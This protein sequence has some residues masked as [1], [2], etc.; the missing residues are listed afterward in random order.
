CLAKDPDRRWQS[1]HDVRLLIESAPESEAPRSD[2]PVSRA[3]RVAPWVLAGAASVAAVAALLARRPSEPASSSTVRFSLPPPSGRTF[4][5]YLE[6]V[7]VAV[8]P[9]GT[10]IVLVVR[11]PDGDS[12]LWL[13]PLSSAQAHPIEG[14]QGGSGPFW[15]PDGRSLGFFVAGQL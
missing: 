2:P 9:D 15:S 3:R 8:S 4:G 11:E 12:R 1:A 14:T 6:A 7:P 5:S 10:Q 13:R